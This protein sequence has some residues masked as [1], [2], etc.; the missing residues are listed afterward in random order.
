MSMT[1]P[2]TWTTLPVRCAVVVCAIRLPDPKRTRPPLCRSGAGDH[3]DDL[4]CDRSLPDLVHLEREVLDHFSRVPRRRI[5]RRHLRRKE[6]R[7]GFEQRAIHLN[8]DVTWQQIAE[9]FFRRGLVE[10]VDCWTRAFTFLLCRAAFKPRNR[11]QALDDNPLRHDGL[12]L[13]VHE[14]DACRGAR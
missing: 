7:V 10:V 4:A 1:G 14:I 9:D 12:E 3:L 8:L 2:M 13:V 6:R 5:H 11:E